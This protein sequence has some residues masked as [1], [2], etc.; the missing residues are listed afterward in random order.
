MVLGIQSTSGGQR[1]E[2]I[3]SSEMSKTPS[4]SLFPCVYPSLIPRERKRTQ[5]QI[6]QQTQAYT[7]HSIKE[8]K[9]W[10]DV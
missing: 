5:R 1:K 2:G 4:V 3:K 8:K 9:M 10:N 7:Q 6:K